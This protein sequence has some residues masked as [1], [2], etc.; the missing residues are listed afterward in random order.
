MEHTESL[1]QEV[2]A[3]SSKSF[4]QKTR[5]PMDKSNIVINKDAVGT[6]Q[7]STILR[8]ALIA[9]TVIRTI[10]Q[11][12]FVLGANADEFGFAIIISRQGLS[13]VSVSLGDGNAFYQPEENVLYSFV[14]R[15]LAGEHQTIEFDVKGQ[16]KLKPGDELLAVIRGGSADTVDARGV[17]TN[18][19]K[20]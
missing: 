2:I 16:R 12:T 6:A 18:F 5:R 3:I 4:S 9:E 15:S 7:V 10:G 14:G 20:Q 11:M 8:N 17:I 19:Y 13:A 1:K